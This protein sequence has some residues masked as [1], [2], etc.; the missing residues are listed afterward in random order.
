MPHP[1]IVVLGLSF[2]F[3][4]PHVAYDE[5]VYLY[6]PIERSRPSGQ[7]NENLE[8][9]E[10]TNVS[11]EADDRVVEYLPVVPADS[12]SDM[13]SLGQNEQPNWSKDYFVILAALVMVVLSLMALIW[14]TKSLATLEKKGLNA[15][16]RLGFADVLISVVGLALWWITLSKFMIVITPIV[17]AYVTFFGFM[18][19][20]QA[21]GGEWSLNRGGM[22]GSITSTVIVVYFFI[23]SMAIFN[24]FRGEVPVYMQTITENFTTTM[25]IVIAFY[26]GASAYV[27]THEKNKD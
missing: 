1:G 26:F 2:P 4:T 18:S 5:G 13:I 3:A 27:Q 15:I 12:Q 24:T 14:I 25:G 23:I 6:Q 16:I 8:N 11:S 19:I 10:T 22:R 9:L 7:M 20:S 17:L 21:M